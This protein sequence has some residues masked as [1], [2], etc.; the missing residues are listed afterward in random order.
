[1]RGVGSMWF[2]SLSTWRPAWTTHILPSSVALTLIPF[3]MPCAPLQANPKVFFDV[4]VGSGADATKLGRIV[5]ELKVRACVV[6]SGIPHAAGACLAPCPI[7]STRHTISGTTCPSATPAQSCKHWAPSMTFPAL[8]LQED[9]TP[10]TAENF[11][12]LALAPAGQGYK[13]SP[14]HRIIPSFMCQ[15]GACL[16]P[17]GASCSLP[18]SALQPFIL[19]YVIKLLLL[20]LVLHRAATSPAATALVAAA[21]TA[22]ASL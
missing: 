12:Q 3:Q 1:M 16:G 14:F 22:S 9:V 8:V 7:P 13:S 2:S 20:V 10:K 21:S 19:V 17:L 6:V 11:K 18:C 4:A 15:V 5:M